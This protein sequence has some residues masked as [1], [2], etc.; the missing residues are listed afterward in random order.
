MSAIFQLAIRGLKQKKLFASLM[1]LVCVI[2]MY[3]VFNA[4]TNAASTVYQQKVFESSLGYQME[5]ILHLDYQETSEDP[6]FT[7][8][9][10]QYRDYIAALP[11]VAAMGQFD[12][13]GIY[14]S[15]LEQSADYQ[16]INGEILKNGKYAAYS[17]RT[18]LLN[19]D[20]ALLSLVK[21]G[22]SDYAETASGYLPIYPSAVFQDILPIG[23]ILTEERTG[24]RYE[25]AGYLPLGSQW[26]A[27]DDL[28]RF[29]MIS[30]DGWFLAPF[31]AS[32][33]TDVI[34]QLSCL[35][36]TYVLLS[37]SADISGLKQAISDFP[38]RH[39]FQASAYSLAEEYESYR[40]ETKALAVRQTG[41]AVFICLM[42]LCSMIAVFTTNALLKRR[43]YGILIANGF[44]PKNITACIAAEI[45]GIVLF[46][47]LIAWVMKL[48]ALHRSTDLFRDILL[49]AHTQYTLPACLAVVPLFICAATLL[50]AIQ[51]F[52]M[53]PCELI[54]GAP[55]GDY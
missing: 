46:S 26:T 14:F 4:I 23:T 2:A 22:I 51:I 6:A 49:T 48:A 17:G 55:Y 28:I 19:V 7:S 41:L 24:E 10:T 5:N 50:P 38:T 11:G 13:T 43:Q 52:K 27:E 54:G 29:P 25:V 39:G 37:D 12:A 35:H 44:T 33:E 42:S 20:E 31:A 45:T 47:T 18:Q 21:G 34:T 30:L 15:E 36:N 8:V 9:L 3:T 1:L 32:S 40:L 16:Q 53:K